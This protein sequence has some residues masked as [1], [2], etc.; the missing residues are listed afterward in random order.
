MSDIDRMYEEAEKLKDEGRLEEATA[1]LEE[2][3]QLDETHVLS[4][5]ALAMLYSKMGKFEEAVQHGE[6]ACELEPDD[7]LNFT[8]LSVAYQRAYAGTQNLG[9]IQKAEEAMAR[10]REIEGTPHRHH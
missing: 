4:H 3:L 10:A 6:R 7:A 2:I 5:M 9:F 1:K 8:A